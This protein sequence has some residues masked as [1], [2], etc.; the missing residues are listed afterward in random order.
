[1]RLRIRNARRGLVQSHAAPAP[2]HNRTDLWPQR[3]SMVRHR[4]GFGGESW[5]RSALFTCALVSVLTTIGIIS[6]L[7]FETITFFGNVSIVE[8]LTGTKWTPLF[9]PQHFGVLPLLTGTLLV[10]VCSMLIALPVGVGSAVYLSEYAPA[11]VREIV[12]PVLE[13]LAGIPTVV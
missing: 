6:V 10:A 12:K 13:V 3:E 4:A 7:L 5:I 11:R 9:V 8:F 2:Q 1:M